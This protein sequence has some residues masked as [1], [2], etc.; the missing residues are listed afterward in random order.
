MLSIEAR[1]KYL[2]SLRALWSLS[3]L[4]NSASKYVIQ[5]KWVSVCL[6]EPCSQIRARSQ[7]YLLDQT[8][9]SSS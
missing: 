6:I 5:N 4:P 2:W 8:A 1:Q 3:Q 7:I 9:N